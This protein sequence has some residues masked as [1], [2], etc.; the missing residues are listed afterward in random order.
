MGPG[1]IGA[2]TETADRVARD[3]LDEYNRQQAA[4]GQTSCY[5]VKRIKY[6]L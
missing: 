3:A 4:L 2:A 6:F 5:K 1:Q